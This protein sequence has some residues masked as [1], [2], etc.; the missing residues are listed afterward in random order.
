MQNSNSTPNPSPGRSPL[1]LD[2]ETLAR[3]YARARERMRA[4]AFGLGDLFA[5]FSP[6]ADEHADEKLDPHA[7]VDPHV[8]GEPSDVSEPSDFGARATL[9]ELL[10]VFREPIEWGLARAE[11]RAQA[12][13]VDVAAVHR[14]RDAIRIRLASAI[15]GIPA[16]TEAPRIRATDLIVVAGL[17]VGTLDPAFVQRTALDASEGLATALGAM[18]QLDP[19]LASTL[20]QAAASLG[21]AQAPRAPH[22]GAT[23]LYCDDFPS[24]AAPF[25]AMPFGPMPFG[26]VPRVPHPAVP[27]CCCRHGRV[28]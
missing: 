5:V 4:S 23:F 27:I 3:A 17:L 22:P 1:A 26:P 6:R 18:L 15:S 24:G 20:A 16:P 25:N 28:L 19:S 13:P 11:Q 9:D 2:Q 14:V 10:R 8:A 12:D 7:Q 21:A